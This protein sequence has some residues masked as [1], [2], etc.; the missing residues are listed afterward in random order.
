MA[1]DSLTLFGA[2]RRIRA[3]LRAHPSYQ[4]LRGKHL[5]VL[6]AC[7]P[8]PEAALLQAAAIQLGAQV[9]LVRY[10][11]GADARARDIETLAGALGRMYDAIDCECL[12]A[13]V[14]AQMARH[15]AVPVIEGLGG[16][17]HRVCALADLMT[18]LE[19]PLPAQTPLSIRLVGDA[20]SPRARELLAAAR[21]IG[22]D[23]LAADVGRELCNDATFV[24]DAMPP[25]CWPLRTRGVALDEARRTDNHLRLVQ[26]V[27]L[28]EMTAC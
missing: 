21:D 12:P 27:L 18:L 23:V 13:P 22:F 17:Q 4:P 19:H 7:P 11:H 25:E 6:M 14:P 3:E 28:D 24:V 10:T 1:A 15:A 2:A 26:A 9:A 8:G 5:A 16:V 20:D